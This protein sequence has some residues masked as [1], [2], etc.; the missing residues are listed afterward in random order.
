MCIVLYLT[1]SM[2]DVDDHSS[3]KYFDFVALYKCCL[4]V[5]SIDL[6]YGLPLAK[7]PLGKCYIDII[8]P[9]CL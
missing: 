1:Y 7:S 2:Q 4:F 5:L 3:T 8:C 9:P 6:C